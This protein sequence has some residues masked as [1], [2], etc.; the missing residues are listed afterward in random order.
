MATVDLHT[1]TTDLIIRP[2]Q[3]ATA[4][5]DLLIG[6]S[7]NDG[8][9]GGEGNDNIRGGAGSDTIRGGAG[10]DRMSGG[11][12]NDHFV[13]NGPGD[14]VNSKSKCDAI[15]DF[16]GAGSN[17]RSVEQDSLNFFGYSATT[18][19]SFAG[20]L[21]GDATKQ[22]YLVHDGATNFGYI[23]VQMADGTNQLG[24]GDYHFFG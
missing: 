18:E 7:G 16:H 6:G 10:A 11:E 4:D 13:F 23:L 22:Y 1:A 2:G 12:G 17:D 5:S 14:L 19:L 24:S 8:I 9:N 15:I 20:Y 3:G 21:G